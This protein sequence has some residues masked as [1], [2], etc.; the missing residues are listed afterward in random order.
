MLLGKS[1]N[2]RFLSTF[3]FSVSMKQNIQTVEVK[4]KQLESE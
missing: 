1:L 2:A 3:I 4:I